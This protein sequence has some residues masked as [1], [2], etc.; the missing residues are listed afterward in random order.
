MSRRRRCADNRSHHLAETRSI[1]AEPPQP[2]SLER[3]PKGTPIAG[4]FLRNVTAYAIYRAELL[5]L[6]VGVS[7]RGERVRRPHIASPGKRHVCWRTVVLAEPLD[8]DSLRG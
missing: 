2:P 6:G 5:H 4:R 3:P 7:I 1:R 8:E